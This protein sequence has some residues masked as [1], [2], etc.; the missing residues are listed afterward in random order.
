MLSLVPNQRAIRIAKGPADKDHIYGVFNKSLMWEAMTKL[1][2]SAFKLWCYF[3]INQNGYEMGLSY[4]DV[5]NCCGLGRST[6][7]AAFN[8]LEEKGYLV[9]VELYPNLPGYVFVESGLSH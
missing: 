7:Y 1:S 2:P 8:E 6:Y 5:H 4:E 9:K 3:G